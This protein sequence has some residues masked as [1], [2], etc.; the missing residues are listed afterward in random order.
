VRVELTEYARVSSITRF[1]AIFP[2]QR[3]CLDPLGIV[4]HFIRGIKLS[5]A[6]RRRTAS[7][8]F[9]AA[10]PICAEKLVPR[11]GNAEP[12]LTLRA[13]SCDSLPHG[14][15]GLALRIVIVLHRTKM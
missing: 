4:R 9:E 5:E 8:N 14:Q 12:L 6:S 2:N 3:L 13:V 10:R 11:L 15:I 1:T 7:A